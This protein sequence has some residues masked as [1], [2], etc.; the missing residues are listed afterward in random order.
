MSG[1]PK[2]APPPQLPGGGGR[3]APRR[4]SP[5]RAAGRAGS[6]LSFS[7]PFGS[8]QA[9][10]LLLG[11]ALPLLFSRPFP[12]RLPSPLP[13]RLALQSSSPRPAPAGP[14]VALVPPRSGPPAARGVRRFSPWASLPQPG[15]T[16]PVLPLFPTVC[17]LLRFLFPPSQPRTSLQISP[18]VHSVRLCF[19]SVSFPLIN[20]PSPSP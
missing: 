15:K 14:S 8:S 13:A 2:R 16:S 3:R 10:R 11:F 5:R 4:R 7:S 18:P 9:K 6:S 1:R 19:L 20:H 12:A 17:S